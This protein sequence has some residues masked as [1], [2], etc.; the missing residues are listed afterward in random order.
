[1]I[2]DMNTNIGNFEPMVRGTHTDDDLIAAL[3]RAEVETALVSSLIT[4]DMVRANDAT[5]AACRR[6]TGR[7]F[8][9]IYLNPTQ[10]EAAIA[11]LE[12]CSKF[13][14]FRG[15]KFHSNFDAYFP[16]EELYF[17]VYERVE[18]TGLPMLWHSGAYPFSN[19]LQIAFVARHFPKVPFILTHFGM[20]DLLWESFPSTALSDNVYVDISGNP[21][22]TV[23]NEWLTYFGA[24]RMLWGSDFPFYNTA[25]ELRK[26]DFLD[27]S[28]A[29]KQLI[30][31]KNVQRL[32]GI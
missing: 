13:D 6:Y 18:Q 9:Y 17:P 23:M 29:D 12:R 10:P 27:C 16:F 28:D 11:E 21:I 8:G 4:N 3:D 22:I 1:M 14:L 15:V 31:C 25:Y 2:I 5:L 32:F 26:V 30:T 20:A 19:P 7:L 24:E